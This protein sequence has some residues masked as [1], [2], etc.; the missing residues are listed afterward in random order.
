M[1]GRSGDTGHHAS[2]TLTGPY[3]GGVRPRV[4]V[5]GAGFGGI[6]AA[7]RLADLPLDTTI[8]D[9]RN[10]HVFQPL[11][12]QVAT[13]GLAPSD[14]ALP[15]RGL[16]QENDNIDFR[17][18]T[19]EKVDLDD[20]VVHVDVG[21]PLP[22]DYLIVAAGS[23]TRWFG[24]PGVE[25]HALAMKT[26]EDATSLRGHILS[27]FERAAAEPAEIDEGALTFVVVGGGPTGVELAGALV[28]LFEVLGRD[29]HHLDVSRARVVLVEATEHLLNGFSDK[30]QQSA[31]ETL[32]ARG[33]ELC[34]GQSVDRAGPGRVHFKNGE[35]LATNTLIWAAG[36]QPAPLA[37]AIGLERGPGG[38]IVV[39]RDLRPPA[40]DNV[41]VVGDLAGAVDH[42]GKPYLQMASVALQQGHFVGR[43]IGRV[44]RG[45]RPWK[46]RYLDYG[47]MATIGRNAAVAELAFGIK[48][49]GALGW[50]AWL[51]VHLVRL[52][53]FRNR[54]SVLFNWAWSYVR[55]D[56]QARLI[57][58]PEDR[59]SRP[60]PASDIGTRHQP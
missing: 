51:L 5:I 40:Y 28:E 31:L 21:P 54:L 36:I 44:A 22:Y 39:R 56:R 59:E 23:Q 11:L 12:Y 4:V 50:W 17:W 3:D 38:R 18:A 45:R 57:V 55:Y 24:I 29:F 8:V 52:A 30:S 13:A 2:R 16:F 42:K 9:Q 41:F 7:T 10:H 33:V 32:E 60:A 49:R 35:V 6:G 46:F 15:V 34:L 19:V 1:V 25:E 14:I 58:H 26:L 20:Q 37:D 47:E 53:G 43:Q 48:L 27:E